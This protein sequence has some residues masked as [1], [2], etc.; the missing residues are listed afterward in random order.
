[1]HGAGRLT[2]QAFAFASGR[3]AAKQAQRG[4]EMVQK[5][6][7]VP[8]VDRAPVELPPLV[9]VV[10]GP[11]GCGKSTL[12][13]SLVKRYSRQNIQDVKGPITVVAGKKQRITFVECGTDLN[14]MLDASK[15]A[16]LVLLMISAQTGF[17]MDTFEFLNMLQVAGFPR[18]IGV[19]SHLDGF[20]DNKALKLT[21]KTLKHRFWTEIYEG[22]K[23]FYLSGLQ[24]GRYMQRDVLNLCRFI[25][26]VKLRPLSWRNSHPYAVADRVEDLTPVEQVQLDP[27]CDRT[28]CFYGYLRGIP[29][30][31]VRGSLQLHI[32]GA[33]D[34]AIEALSGLADPCPLP[35]GE[36]KKT[37]TLNDR[38]RLIYAPMADLSGIVYDQ[39]AVY[40][41]MP[42]KNNQQGREEA[43]ETASEAEEGCG[44]DGERML[45]RIKRDRRPL[46]S[47]IRDSKLT[48]FRGAAAIGAGDLD[49]GSEV[50]EDDNGSG[51]EAP[52]DDN[53]SGFEAP[54]D[55]N[56]SDHDDADDDIYNHNDADPDVVDTF[57]DHD[58]DTAIIDE[59]LEDGDMLELLR[60]RFITGALPDGGD[61]DDDDDE[62]AGGFEDLEAG[63][64]AAAAPA[65]DALARKK[66]ELKK[67]FDAEF[68]SR[69]DP[70]ADGDTADKTYYEEMKASLGKQQALNRA[71]Y[72]AEDPRTREQLEG[73]QPGTYVRILVARMP[74]EYMD[75]FD[76]HR[77][78]LLGG[79]LAN[80]ASLG[81]CQARIKKHRWFGK[82]LKNNEPLVVSAGWR[83]FQTCPL[84][85]MQDAT[86]NRLVKYTPDHLHCMATFYGPVIPQNTGLL[87]FRSIAEGQSQFRVSAT[88]VVLE[89]DQS[90]RVL[91]KLK[92]VGHP[93]EVHRN[94]AFVR[95]MFNSPL[96]VAR[97]E[98]AALRTVSG[99]RGQLKKA[100]RSPPGSFRASFEDK[101]LK[102]D[103]VFLRTWYAVK[104]R[105]Y[106]NPVQSALDPAW[107][108]MRLNAQ[109]R[110]ATQTPLA[111]R[112]D[113]HY[114]PVERAPR[115]FN[116]LK[117][118]KS[119]QRALPYASKPKLT[120]PSTKAGRP[121]YAARRAVVLESA[122]RKALSLLQAIST[123]SR[124]KQAKRQAKQSEQRA[125]YQKKVAK[126][127]AIKD[128][129]LS[130]KI[131]KAV[132]DK[133]RREQRSQNK[134]RDLK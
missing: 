50:S 9:V 130:D 131:R 84:F 14:S 133:A 104:P 16:D 11:K 63:E 115:R 122:E 118:P 117:V 95:D 33:G 83:R 116:T 61:D 114:R 74:C 53:D 108:G 28:V 37:K 45:S 112:T 24:H 134:R 48:L 15:I 86:R 124:Q 71:A 69:F 60:S 98:G 4:Q 103:I 91:K 20:K 52:E 36:A 41:D 59:A 97:F 49:S 68:D 25:S 101:I 31:L 26:V 106:Y 64:A 93:H 87:A 89:Y 66:A 23:L 56:V 72:A 107:T 10:A 88:G 94:T 38:Q 129:K 123:V 113:S 105:P 78:V 67:K 77:V 96:E 125:L 70:A 42:S 8:V 22:A 5:K 76:A 21:K 128:A 54:E 19:L 120:Q 57:A 132:A 27:K 73:L 39:D 81:Y 80:E 30:K 46:D 43:D 13:R 92:L 102:S 58:P 110:E 82:T 2:W 65:E 29:L 40:I 90:V 12:V 7:H 121:S 17:T 109:V 119:L 111:V 55:G 75:N 18:V 3:K 47:G 6:L 85:S 79:L 100:E 99:I 32:P 126:E 62:H 1:M 44:P 34:F 127:T 51:S 35:A